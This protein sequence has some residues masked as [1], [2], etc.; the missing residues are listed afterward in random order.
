MANT[1]ITA[2]LVW[3]LLWGWLRARFW[4]LFYFA[5]L[6]GFYALVYALHGYPWGAAGYAALLG[7]AAGLVLAAASFARFAARHLALSQAAGRFPTAGLPPPATLTDADYTQAIHALEAERARLEQENESARRDA[8][9]YYTLWAH[10]VKTPLA[11][12]HLLLQSAGGAPLNAPSSADAEQELF[13]IGQYVG[14]VLQYQRLSSLQNDLL[15]QRHSLA[16][17]A[18]QAGKN[19]ATLFIHKK[20]AL[21]TEAVQGSLVTDRKWFVFVLEQLYTNAVKYS[22]SGAVRVFSQGE[23][24]LVV[25]DS[26][27]GIPPEDLPRVFEKG[28]TGAAGRRE[29]SST[30]IGLYLCR[31]ILARLGFGISIESTPGQGTRVLLHLAQTAV[32]EE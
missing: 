29:R 8:A 1:K 24:T 25:E 2:P 19:C 6:Y 31:Q 7:L 16:A 30:G 22:R 26:G 17:L 9:E 28:F 11:A 21:E 5:L 13:R 15:L 20:L 18:R 10:Q 4:V 12:L 23:S 3:A 14:M 27:Q 32:E